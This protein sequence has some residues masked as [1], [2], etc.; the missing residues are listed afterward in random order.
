MPPTASGAS[1]V[2]TPKL[3]GALALLILF[4]AS[5][6]FTVSY[7]SPVQKSPGNTEVAAAAT[8]VDPFATVTLKAR[9]AYVL[10]MKMGRV[11]Y[12]LNPDAQL[13]LASLAKVPLTLVVAEVLSPDTV[14]TIPH[15]TSPRGSA[16]RLA[17]GQKWSVRD[18]ITFTLVASSNAGAEILAEATNDPIRARYPQAP[19]TP[20]DGAT[21]WRV[22]ELI[23]ELGLTHTYF[24]NV[25]GLD[26]STSQAGAFGSAHDV[27]E[28]F[29][30][31]AAH[32]PEI[33]G[34]TARDGL[35]LTSESGNTT[36][37]FN[38]DKALGAIPGLIMGKT[39]T[40]D[41]AGANLAIVFDVGPAHPVVAVV[42]GSTDAGRF[43]DMKALVDATENAVALQ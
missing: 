41:L 12:S 17:A 34:G 19:D 27:A 21:L 24:L 29:A 36:S 6:A 10:D 20:A 40:T 3:L 31:A 22:N 30:Y 5:V 26:L 37:A 39:G 18:V 43:E 35:L 13:P 25:T 16:E 33:F 14:I 32:A 4:G 23:Q 7:F 8:T 42:L 28:I 9:A 15:D 38:T 1:S 2:P 11:L